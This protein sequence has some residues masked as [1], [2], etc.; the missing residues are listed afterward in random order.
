MNK[1]KGTIIP[2]GGNEDKGSGSSE[3]YTLQF[4]EGGILYSVLKEAKGNNSSVTVITTASKIP[5]AVGETYRK[6]FNALG[7]QGITILDIRSIVQANDP[8]NLKIIED[9][10]C[11]MFSGGDQSEI[12]KHIKGTLM[13]EIIL[14]KLRETE[15]VVAGTSAGAMCMSSEMIAGGSSAEA[16]RK[17]NVKMSHGMCF[18]PNAII[19]SHFIQRGRF[20]R[21]AEALA[22]FPH[23]LGIGLSEDTGII[24]KES[25]HCRVIGSGM[26]L[27][28]DATHLTHN[29]IDE[30]QVGT[31][32]S[33]C[34][35]ITH[36]LANGDEFSLSKR[37]VKVLSMSEE[38]EWE[39]R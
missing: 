2:I 30:L 11:L 15:F 36:I 38:F 17:G 20:G 22:H 9:T 12:V 29:K 39:K 1:F 21:L 14:R 10:D 24:I 19:D 31:P 6:A 26:I 32:L 37:K 18:V 33:M 25:D 7:C 8:R 16:F 3:M 27:L 28:F 4:V 5:K 34:H 13:H 35:L 23:L